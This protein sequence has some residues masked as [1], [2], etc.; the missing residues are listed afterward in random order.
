MNYISHSSSDWV[1]Q[2]V[3]FSQSQFSAVCWGDWGI[4]TGSSCRTASLSA[5]GHWSMQ[6]VWLKPLH[7][8]CN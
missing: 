5:F 1:V 4:R 8:L 3:C 7:I 6:N 2:D